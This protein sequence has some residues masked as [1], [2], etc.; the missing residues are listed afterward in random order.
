MGTNWKKWAKAALIRAI[1]T[2]AESA[3]AYIGTGALVLGDVNWL[4]VL[5]A[6]AFGFILAI[7]IALTGLPEV[8][9]E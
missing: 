6:G 2:F 3:L 5:S 9:E 4:G 8:D 1:R 7:L